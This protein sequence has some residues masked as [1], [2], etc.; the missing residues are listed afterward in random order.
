MT[1]VGSGRVL[2]VPK[3]AKLPGT[4]LD[5]WSA[6]GGTNQQWLIAPSDHGTY[7]IEARSS[8]DPVDVTGASEADGAAVTQWPRNGGTNQQWQLVAVK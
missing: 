1:G 6:N 7:T 8:G 4:A 5:L 2:D 3:A